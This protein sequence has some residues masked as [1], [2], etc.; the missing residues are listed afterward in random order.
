MGEGEPTLR[1]FNENSV[2]FYERE[3]T[4][5]RKLLNFKLWYTRLKVCRLLF[6]LLMTL[7]RLHAFK[8]RRLYRPIFHRSPTARF[9]I[10]S[11]RSRSFRRR[12]CDR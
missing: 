11:R 8:T 4:T 12:C 3:I 5:T 6:S 7:S 9:R 2:N 1:V 10:R